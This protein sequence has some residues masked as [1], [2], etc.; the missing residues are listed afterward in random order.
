MLFRSVP[1]SEDGKSSGLGGNLTE[2]WRSKPMFKFMV[3]VIGVFAVG[4]AAFSFMGGDKQ[5][6]IAKIATPPALKEVA[7]GQASPYMRE[8]TEMANKERAEQAAATGGSALPTPIGQTTDVGSFGATEHK[9][10]ALN[11][12]RAE[13]EV[14]RKQ[15][16]Q[17]QVQQQQQMQ[18]RQP[19]AFD[20]SLAEA[21]DR[22]STRLNSSHEWISRMPSSA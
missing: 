7:G 9:D 15:M 14:L 21:I 16:Q 20:N 11:E 22:K 10:E 17:Q 18:Q 19:E 3:L 1:L 12:L 5:A 2:A 8:Q 4:V 6:E 13:T